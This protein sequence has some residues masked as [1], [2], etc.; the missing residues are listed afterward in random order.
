MNMN[1]RNNNI[2]TYL[3]ICFVASLRTEDWGGGGSIT[4]L[5]VGHGTVSKY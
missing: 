5:I 3:L 4:L 2:S 1:N